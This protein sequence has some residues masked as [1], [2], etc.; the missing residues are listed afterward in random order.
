MKISI[1]LSRLLAIF[2]IAGLVFA[3]LSRPANAG[4]GVAMTAPVAAEM[5][6]EMPCC[7]DKS[8]PMDCDQCPLMALCMVTN[9]HAPSPVGMIEIRP[10]TVRLLAPGS[11]PEADSLGQHPPPR[12][13]RSLVRS[14]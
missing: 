7:P 2:V 11:D 3:P 1:H 13:P 10:V 5:A 8:V 12:P 9:F 14:A 4:N 6:A